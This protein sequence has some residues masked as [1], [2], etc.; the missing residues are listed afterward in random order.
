[1]R[2][3]TSSTEVRRVVVPDGAPARGVEPNPVTAWPPGF[4]RTVSDAGGTGE[5]AM[6]VRTALT[7]RLTSIVHLPVIRPARSEPTSVG[8]LG[9]GF[10]GPSVGN[11][12]PFR[13]RARPA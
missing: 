2:L 11:P 12:P 8:G 10:L 13:P 7:F 5:P 9:R 3:R 1:A 4:N 6:F